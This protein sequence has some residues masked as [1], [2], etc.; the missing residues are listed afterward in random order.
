MPMQ[1]TS[2]EA[3][4]VRTYTSLRDVHPAGGRSNNNSKGKSNSPVF[5]ANYHFNAK[6]IGRSQGRSATGSA[7]YRAGVDLVDRTT[8]LRFDYTRKQGIDG[9]EILAPANAPAWCSD[10]SELWN[11]VEEAEK[12]KDA[13]VCREVEFSLPVELTRDEMKELAREFVRSQFVSQGMVADV[14]FHHLDSHNP[15]AHVLL[16]MRTLSP[17]GEGFGNKQREWND[18]ALLESWRERWASHANG[19]LTKAG[20]AVRIDHRSLAEQAYDAA[21]RGDMEAAQVLDR[22]P[23]F[24]EGGSKTRAALN[25]TVR[26]ENVERQ[27]AWDDTAEQARAEARLMHPS[28]DTAP[29]PPQPPRRSH[30]QRPRALTIDRSSRDVV[31]VRKHHD[32]SKPLLAVRSLDMPNLGLSAGGG[33]AGQHLGAGRLLRTDEPRHI[34]AGRPMQQ[35]R[36][37]AQPPLTTRPSAPPVAAAPRP[38]APSAGA[39]K[40]RTIRPP[41]V[42]GSVLTRVTGNGDR[43]SEKHA[44]ASERW[45]SGLDDYVAQL[46]RSA[47]AFAHRQGDLWIK[48]QARDLVTAGR[49]LRI[50]ER[51]Q[52][53]ACGKHTNAKD[54]RL[55]RS[56]RVAGAVREF[57]NDPKARLLFKITRREPQR[58]RE[59][60]EKEQRA[61]ERVAG[62]RKRRDSAGVAHAKA[63]EDLQRRQDALV[64]EWQTRDPSSYRADF[65]AAWKRCQ[66]VADVTSTPSPQ[67]QPEA[68]PAATQTPWAALPPTHAPPPTAPRP[69]KM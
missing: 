5:M 32:G 57:E 3:Q 13:Q 9:A 21:L 58:L 67:P 40:V 49:V 18:R 39:P 29:Q 31:R 19:A 45:L 51:Q 33:R 65:M 1:F 54:S 28:Y 61:R 25:D 56:Q 44:R 27:K 24:H 23:T 35:L 60:R 16:T 63:L 10:R 11:R 42:G 34:R 36:A 30:G 52:Q 14:A 22:A 46:I 20:H 37:E 69:P 59:M 62:T 55:R 66:V 12:R 68:T 53:R 4:Q 50:R 2:G 48:S 15:H 41:K 26:A 43:E 47:L 64:D 7:A 38:K 17:D 8:G 6:V